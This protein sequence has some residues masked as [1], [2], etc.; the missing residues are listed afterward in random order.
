MGLSFQAISVCVCVC[1]RVRART[2]ALYMY[3]FYMRL[4]LCVYVLYLHHQSNYNINFK[5]IFKG[6]TIIRVVD[7]T[8]LFVQYTQLQ[9]NGYKGSG[10]C[11][12]LPVKS[13]LRV[14]DDNSCY[15]KIPFDIPCNDVWS[16]TNRL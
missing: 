3:V 15:L 1:V 9:S 10:L 13:I 16:P 8:K 11:E 6:T 12:N 14:S 7:W 5:N 2:Y 4:W